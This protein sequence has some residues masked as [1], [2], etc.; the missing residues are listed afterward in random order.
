MGGPKPPMMGTPAPGQAQQ[1]GRRDIA[2]PPVPKDRFMDMLSESHKRT[3]TKPDPRLLMVIQQQIDLYQL[4]NEVLH[5]GGVAN[6]SRYSYPSCAPLN[7]LEGQ[8]AQSL[9]CHRVKAQPSV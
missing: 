7:V 1:P 2:M 4:H 9:E 6:V 5:F 8:A 3:G